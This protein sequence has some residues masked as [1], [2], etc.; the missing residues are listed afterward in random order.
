MKKAC[1]AIPSAESVREMPEVVNNPRFARVGTRGMMARRMGRPRKGEE[2]GG[3][4]PTTIRLP[5]DVLAKV[6]RFA[7]EHDASVG[8]VLRYAVEEYVREMAG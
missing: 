7:Q 5:E 1:E 3:T 2:T 4:V 8:A 6:T